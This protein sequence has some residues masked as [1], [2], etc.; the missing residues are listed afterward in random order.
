MLSAMA[1][2]IPSLLILVAKQLYIIAIGYW[3]TYYLLIQNEVCVERRGDSGRQSHFPI[4]T[5]DASPPRQVFIPPNL[6]T[7]THL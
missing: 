5:R 7:P 6:P 1:D 4:C 3:D 2:N